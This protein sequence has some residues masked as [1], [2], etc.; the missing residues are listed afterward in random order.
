[1]LPASGF[2]DASGDG[3]RRTGSGSVARC[4]P[5]SYIT[6]V[7]VGRVGGV[8]DGVGERIER[9]FAEGRRR[10]ACGRRN[11]GEFRRENLCVNRRTSLSRVCFWPSM[12]FLERYLTLCQRDTESE[13]GVSVA[14]RPVT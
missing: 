11:L 9:R 13:Q 4:D 3:N 6:Q 14:V 5:H 1:M 2:A 7:R 10:R 12:L 8:D